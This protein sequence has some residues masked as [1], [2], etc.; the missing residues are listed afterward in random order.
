MCWS[1]L[2]LP[3]RDPSPNPL[4][5]S[6]PSYVPYEVELD[7]DEWEGEAVFVCRDDDDHIRVLPAESDGD[8]AVVAPSLGHENH[9][10]RAM[11]KIMIQNDDFSDATE[12]LME[13][14]DSIRRTIDG[15]MAAGSAAAAVEDDGNNTNHGNNNVRLDDERFYLSGFLLSLADVHEA[16][17][18]YGKMKDALDESLRLID[19]MAEDG[20]RS[21]RRLHVLEKLALHATLTKNQKA[22]ITY[23]EEAIALG[24][25]ISDQESYRLGTLLYDCGRLNA[26]GQRQQR[27][28]GIEQ[29]SKGVEILSRVC[30]RQDSRVVEARET[31]EAAMRGGS[32]GD[33][34]R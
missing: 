19:E 20:E 5:C 2:V 34:R 4:P 18:E 24:Q 12:L 3:F 22:N 9:F 1:L 7:D 8:A 29:M 17:G 16:Q 33:E 10:V 6:F 31:L 27:E 28:R 13:R 15:V 21:R 25:E 32:D 11:S 30:G 23:L 26:A 14:I